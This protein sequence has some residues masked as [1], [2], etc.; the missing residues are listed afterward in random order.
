[1]LER[2]ARSRILIDQG[3]LLVLNAAHLM[4]TVGNIHRHRIAR[5]ELKR[6]LK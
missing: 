6:Q 3:R 2:I 1:M 5:L 4:D